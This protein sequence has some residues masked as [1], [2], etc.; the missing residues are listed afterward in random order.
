MESN[1]GS[2]V[3]SWW[4]VVLISAAVWVWLTCT[5]V[6][7]YISCQPDGWYEINERA[8]KARDEEIERGV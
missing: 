5:V 3:M 2:E 6:I 1:K 4:Q 8:Q 7:I